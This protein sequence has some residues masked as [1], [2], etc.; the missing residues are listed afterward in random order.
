MLYN[1]SI[2]KVVFIY[3]SCSFLELGVFFLPGTG[4]SFGVLHC[5]PLKM[6]AKIMDTFVEA[7]FWYLLSKNII[8]SYL[9]F[10]ITN[11]KQARLFHWNGKTPNTGCF[12]LDWP[13]PL[14]HT[15]LMA[16]T[17][18]SRVSILNTRPNSDD[19]QRHQLLMEF[20]L[21]VISSVGWNY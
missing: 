20:C 11:W 7:Q 13:S 21:W 6:R 2:T 4:G 14:Y 3:S 9:N 19:K 12:C 17:H 1:R 8:K 18:K 5:S 16:C 10:K 15:M